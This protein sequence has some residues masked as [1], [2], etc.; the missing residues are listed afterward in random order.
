MPEALTLRWPAR[1]LLRLTHDG[2]RD[3]AGVHGDGVHEELRREQR[4]GLQRRHVGIV[5]GLQLAQL[6]RG[7]I[8]AQPAVDAV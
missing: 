6:P 3:E 1:A 2:K 8:R 4:L 7:N 5:A